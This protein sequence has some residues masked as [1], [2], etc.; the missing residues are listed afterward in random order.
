MTPDG[1][2]P[3]FWHATIMNDG[4]API[5]TYEIWVEANDD[6]SPDS[7]Y[8]KFDIDITEAINDPPVIE[9]GVDGN[10]I[11]QDDAVELYTVTA[12][13]D[14]GILTYHWIVTDDQDI[15][16]I[17]VPGD[18][19]GQLEIDWG[20][21]G[22]NPGDSFFIE[23]AVSD[24][25][26]P[27]VDATTLQVVI[28]L[29]PGVWS[30][31]ILVSGDASFD[32]YLPRIVLSSTEYWIIYATNSNEV[33]RTSS[34]G[35][36]FWS[37]PSDIDNFGGPDTLHAVQGLNGDIFIQYQHSSS[38]ETYI[39]QY[40]S[41][42]WSGPNFNNL[43]GL[44]VGPYAADLGISAGGT[45]FD[46][47][48]GDWS[49]FAHHSEFPYDLSSWIFDNVQTFYNANYSVNDGMVQNAENAKIFFV[50]DGTQLDYGEFTTEWNHGAAWNPTDTIIEPAIAPESDNPYHGIMGLDKGGTYDVVYFRFDNWPPSSPTLVTLETGLTQEPVYHSI[51][52]EGD[53]ISVLY[54]ADGQV[55]FDESTDGGD[56]FVGR[57]SFG[58]GMFSHI[59]N[60]ANR[61]TLMAAYAV[62]EGSDYN[63]YVR[64][65]N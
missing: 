3:T 33:A 63:I 53:N 4:G 24:G 62:D 27:P 56:T 50:H 19:T 15:E 58:P 57:T 51:S 7:L 48:T 49:F 43:H 39:K 5:G 6:T 26:N 60:D 29:P 46:M 10:Q 28:S 22:V 2:D 40:S 44:T 37:D 13:D 41:G 52:A 20:A 17:N 31:P 14:G 45:I 38:K 47:W 61:S 64:V 36:F 30:E 59:R 11:P 16:K 42:Q 32:E 1:G 54:D 12:S 18:L 55:F 35:G 21:L 25:V 23:C 8:N 65:R 34:T 9:S